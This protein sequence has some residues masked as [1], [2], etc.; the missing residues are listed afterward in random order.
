MCIDWYLIRKPK[1]FAIALLSALSVGC[2]GLTSHNNATPRADGDFCKEARLQF[3][4]NSIVPAGF[5]FA[6]TRF[7]GI[8][9]IDYDPDTERWYLISDDKGEYGAPRYYEASLTLNGDGPGIVTVRDV[10]FLLS[11]E[12]NEDRARE[13]AQVR[14]DAE[15]IRHVPLRNEIVWTNEGDT[16]SGFGPSVFRRNL[17][18]SKTMELTL[19]ASLRRDASKTRG[20]RDNRSFEGLSVERGGSFWLGLETGLIEQ[21]PA[22]TDHA[23]ANTRFLHLTAEGDVI[24]EVV[25]PMDA[26]PERVPGLLADN[27]VSETLKLPGDSMLVIERA[28]R[29]TNEG[30]FE[31]SVRLYCASL[32]ANN[33]VNRL[34]SKKLLGQLHNRAPSKAANFEGLAFGPEHPDGG[35][36][37]VL[38]ADNNFADGVPTY[39][40]VYRLTPDPFR[41]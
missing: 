27:G 11:G 13:H 39:F 31:F 25:Y 1:W 24:E 34:V 7:G 17:T 38:A 33:A 21:G 35:R 19:H 12:G 18:T 16:K 37:L 29:Q 8:S 32:P 5:E 10:V 41:Q 22:P 26:I 2:A 6:G 20:P 23:G 36:Y 14:I 30:G 15:A 40:S 4:G 28:G 3:I 9:G